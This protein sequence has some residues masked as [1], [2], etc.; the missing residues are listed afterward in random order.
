MSTH[1]LTTK[2]AE[3]EYEKKS[4]SPQRSHKIQWMDNIPEEKM[5]YKSAK[6]AYKTPTHPCVLRQ[7]VKI[8]GKL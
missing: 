3:S 8:M 4:C 1:D 6:A 5:V 2:H 7:P